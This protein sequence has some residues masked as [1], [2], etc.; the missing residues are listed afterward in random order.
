MPKE[1]VQQTAF[2][3]RSTFLSDRSTERLEI[4]IT[5]SCVGRFLGGFIS[6]FDAVRRNRARLCAVPGL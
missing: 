4:Q 3:S 2:G 5:P 1:S 6:P